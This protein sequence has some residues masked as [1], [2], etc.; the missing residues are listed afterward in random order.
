MVLFM[1]ISATSVVVPMASA[2]SQA[3]VEDF[4]L[5]FSHPAVGRVYVGSLY[6]YQRNRFFLPV[7]ELFNR[8]EIR[9]QRGSGRNILEGIFLTGGETYTMDFD[10]RTIRLGRNTYTF[11][12]DDMFVGATDYYLSP[13]VFQTVFDMFFDVSLQTLGIRLETP[14]TMPLAERKQRESRQSELVRNGTQMGQQGF[15]LRF[16]KRRDLFQTGFLD[17]QVSTVGSFDDPT[18]NLAYTFTG[19][20]HVLGGGLQGTLAGSYDAILGVTQKAD[21]VSWRYAMNP[22]PWLTDVTIGQIGTKGL[23]NERVMGLSITN[24]PVEPRQI[25]GTY[26]VDGRVDPESD[27]ELYM[28]NTLID[29]TT[30]DA[31]GYYRFD[32]PL[33]YGTSRLQTRI[34]TPNGELR[35]R[36]QEFQVPFVFLPV[37]TVSYNAEAGRIDSQIGIDDEEAFAMHGNV[38]IG[39]TDWLTAR[40][41][42]DHQTRPGEVPKPYAVASAR[43]LGSYLVNIEAVPD[44]FYKAQTAV[45]FPTSHS[46]AV[47]YTYFDGE[48]RYNRQDALHQVSGSAYLPVRILN[49]GIRGS[50]EGFVFDNRSAWRLSSD[51]FTR[52]GRLNLR[53]NYSEQ[54]SFLPE[55]RQWSGGLMRS[56]ATVSMPKGSGFAGLF[57]GAFVRTSTTYDIRRKELRQVDGQLSQSVGRTGRFTLGVSHLMPQGITL[58]QVGLNLDLG[59]KARSSTDYRGRKNQHQYRQSVRGSIGLDSRNTHLMFTDRA[60]VGGGASTITLFVDNSGSGTYEPDKGD[61]LLPY[62]AIRLDR[63]ALARVDR[64][65]RVRLTQLQSYHTYNLEV[66]RRALPNPL[67]VPGVDLFSFVADPHQ[68]KP[69]EI[70]FYRTGVIDGVVGMR[71]NGAFDGIGGLRLLLTGLDR[72]YTETIHS[73]QEGGFYAMDIPPGRYTLQADTSQLAFLDAIQLGGAI[74]VTVESRPNGHYL[75]GIQVVLVP[76]EDSVEPAPEAINEMENR[77]LAAILADANEAMALYLEAQEKLFGGNLP[78]ARDAINRSLRLFESDHGIALK[79]SIEYMLG[80][81]NEALRLWQDAR[82]RNPRIELPDTDVLDYLLRNMRNLQR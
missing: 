66:N 20:A 5:I 15:P 45:V 31:N 23:Q 6:D 64:D 71:R 9:Y 81:R 21:Q 33:R 77:V 1:A 69:I 79:G 42:T 26:Q 82:R 49:A 30:A 32:V 14:H 27:V 60:Q 58:A 59:G 80:N 50:A 78:D 57:G 76:I 70:P 4:K 72:D 48:S 8:L 24:E 3:D 7:V 35:V 25:Y 53:V 44:A 38:G 13:Q 54:V 16:P 39:I 62:N 74:T 11:G 17:Y 65:G 67:L 28:N 10:R 63:S 12:S 22:N 19:A 52:V 34:I 68:F 46:L 29:F 2:Q 41:G 47:A 75:E 36:D 61:E 18:R 40:V 37:G 51:V 73:F 55:G 56:S 43:L